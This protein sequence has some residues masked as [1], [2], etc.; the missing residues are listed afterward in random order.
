M[1]L[2]ITL[3]DVYHPYRRRVVKMIPRAQEPKG[4]TAPIT[5]DIFL[6]VQAKMPEHARP[7]VWTLLLT[8]ARTG[9]YLRLQHKYERLKRDYEHAR[10]A[11]ENDLVIAD[12]KPDPLAF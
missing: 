2:T 6:A 4:R 1:V 8:D 3:G 9:E 5:L 7:C 12:F 10:A 11:I